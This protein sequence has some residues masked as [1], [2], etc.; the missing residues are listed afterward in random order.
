MGELIDLQKYRQ[1]TKEREAVDAVDELMAKLEYIILNLKPDDIRAI[2]NPI[3]L[4]VEP[5]LD[6]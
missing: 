1:D 4:R 6:R 3:D 5:P 2:Y